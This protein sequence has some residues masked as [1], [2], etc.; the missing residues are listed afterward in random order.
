MVVVRPFQAIR[1]V[2]EKVEEVVSPPYDV[3]N[4]SEAKGMVKDKPFSFLHVVKP[5]ID[6]DPSI[7]QYDHRVY[8]KGKEKLTSLINKEILIQDKKPCIYIYKLR[9]GKHNQVGLV[10]LS[11]VED[12]IQNKIKKHENTRPDKEKDRLNHII[13]VNAH[14][15]PVFLIHHYERKIENLINRG[16][17][18]EPVYDFVAD[19]GIQHTFYIVN[20]DLLIQQIIEAFSKLDCLYVADGHHRS[21]AAAG[22]REIKMKENPNHT[23][24][25][26]YNFF[27]TVVFP[28]S[29]MRILDYNRVVKD[30]NGM[31]NE[32][33]LTKV[34]DKFEIKSY[35]KPD[36]S[37]GCKPEKMHTFGM[38]LNEQWYCLMSKEGTFDPS[39]PIGQLDVSILQENLLSPLLG[40]KDPRTDKR[41][42]FVGGIRGL[43]ELEILV[44][45][46]EY[47][48][49]F[50][51]FPTSIDQLI[52]VADAGKVMPPK[53]TW[54][55]PKLRSGL[56]THLLE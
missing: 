35:S 40:I 29:H 19:Y 11:S 47:A 25:E 30:L 26:A 20:D 13:G 2:H 22:V 3:I 24:E 54:F 45:S 44:D 43:K 6:L 9:M 27:L 41:I 23:G 8:L 36:G 12:Y 49:A 32:E 16:M 4:S 15:G 42:N 39:D 1:P 55:E 51:L 17:E 33:L 48:V 46:G 18:V 28:D 56:V 52:A 53:S 14:T 10:A 31:S 21:A 34:N 38:Y 37:E 5:E 50:S 7:D